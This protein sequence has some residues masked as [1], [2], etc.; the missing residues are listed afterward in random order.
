MESEE[1]DD[2]ELDTKA[3][4]EQDKSDLSSCKDLKETVSTAFIHLICPF[5]K[6][7]RSIYLL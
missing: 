5:V 6:M 4:F 2:Y 7:I 3:F 1:D